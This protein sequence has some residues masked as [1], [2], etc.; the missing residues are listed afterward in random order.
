MRNLVAG[1]GSFGLNFDNFG[2]KI[3]VRASKTCPYVERHVENDDKNTYENTKTIGSIYYIIIIIKITNTILHAHTKNTV[4]VDIPT[5]LNPQSTKLLQP[6]LI[7][8]AL[9]KNTKYS[10]YNIF[11]KEPLCTSESYVKSAT[12]SSFMTPP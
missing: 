4:P 10:C 1:V 3:V 2:V 5:W 8:K 7:P 12:D 11:F 6:G 9:R